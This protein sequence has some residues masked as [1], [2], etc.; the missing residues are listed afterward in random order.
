MISRWS[1]SLLTLQIDAVVS[2]SFVILLTFNLLNVGQL[3]LHDRISDPG[4]IPI[5]RFFFNFSV[6]M[7][8]TARMEAPIGKCLETDFLG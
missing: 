3:M 5:L 4:V 8:F 6:N 7:S 1:G 2:T